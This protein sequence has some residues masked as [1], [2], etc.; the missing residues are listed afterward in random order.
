M[1]AQHR[2]YY[3]AAGNR[4]ISARQTEK[5]GGKNI[6]Q[7]KKPQ[8]FC[9]GF[10]ISFTRR[11]W[12]NQQGRYAPRKSASP[13]VLRRAYL[14]QCLTRVS[15]IAEGVG[16]TAMPASRSAFILSSA[17]PEFPETIAPA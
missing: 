14:P 2:K 16:E 1:Q 8:H 5:F 9:C 17:E 13:D 6:A 11:E 10:G 15:P 7:P 4:K 3:S 12:R